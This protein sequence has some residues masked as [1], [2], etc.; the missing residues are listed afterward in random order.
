MAWAPADGRCRGKILHGGDGLGRRAFS[1]GR[2]CCEAFGILRGN[3]GCSMENS[4]E[5]CQEGESWRY[6]CG[7]CGYN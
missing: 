2:I 3:V 6:K 4:G 5:V 1:L 7:S